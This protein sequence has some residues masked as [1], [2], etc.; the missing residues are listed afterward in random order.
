MQKMTDV[1][2]KVFSD[3]EDNIP[4]YAIE[5]AMTPDK[6]GVLSVVYERKEAAEALLAEYD[7]YESCEAE[8]ADAVTEAVVRFFRDLKMLGGEEI[9]E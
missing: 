8:L 3:I 1:K 4:M 9:D 6:S 2:H 7:T 5:I